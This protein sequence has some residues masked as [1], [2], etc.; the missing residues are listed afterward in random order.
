MKWSR[1]SL[2]AFAIIVMLFVLSS[3]QGTREK[4]EG[5]GLIVLEGATLI[6]GTGSAL[7]PNS[8]VVLQGTRILRVGQVGD[9]TY[10]PGSRVLDVAGKWIVPGFVDTHAHMPAP[11]DQAAVLK[12]L[13]AFGITTV[14][15]P[16]GEPSALA[17]RDRIARGRVIASRLVTAGNIIDEP[18]GIFSGAPWVTEVST[19][20][21]VRAEVRRQIGESVDLIKVYRGMAPALVQA[22][23]DES[24]RLGRPVLGHLGSTTWSEAADFGIDGFAHFGIFG[25]PW[26]LVPEKD[27]AAVRHACQE[28]DNG[29][30]FRKLRATVSAAS[31]NTLSWA[32]L[33]ASRRVTVEPNLVLL[34]AVFWGDDPK[35]LEMMEPQYAP[36]S[37]HDGRW[38]DAIPHPYRAPCT[39]EWAEEAQAT[40]PLFEQLVLVLQKEGVILTIGT[41]LMNPWMTPGVSYHRELELLSAAGIKPAD[42]LVA[43]TSAGATAL[44]LDAEVGTV[45]QGM[46]A[47]LVVLG[48]NPLTQIR[49]TRTI[50]SVFLRG[51]QFRPS[52]LLA[53]Q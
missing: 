35:T 16:G 25:T 20:K 4:L 13:V 22:A 17:L 7:R 15:N 36:A 50:E 46:A 26:E 48:S 24:H 19:E 31:E 3:C 28:C 39:S 30:G 14:R 27:Q 43:A 11:E 1:E 47:D 38:F 5:D 52:D 23:V 12:T 32:R 42:V 18:G 29:E 40:Y 45:R 44:G 10:P 6:D 41:D 21:E 37:W 51:A 33:L 49:N 8:V 2:R 53:R 34:Q 9:F